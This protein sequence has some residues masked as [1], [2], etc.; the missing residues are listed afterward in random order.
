[1]RA[2]KV[3]PRHDEH[4]D[5]R[6]DE[7]HD[8]RYDEQHDEYHH[9]ERLEDI[10][11]TFRWIIS[12]AAEEDKREEARQRENVNVTK[13]IVWYSLVL[14]LLPGDAQTLDTFPMA[15]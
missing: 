13:P 11:A 8:E 5:E 2:A 7:S 14:K 10:L 15:F 9:H 3:A 12:V 1:M 6:H 4:R